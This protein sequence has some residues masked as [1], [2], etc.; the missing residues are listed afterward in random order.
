MRP[1]TATN[2]LSGSGAIAVRTIVSRSRGTS[3]LS[4]RSGAGSRV[5]TSTQVS[6]AVAAWNG[7][8]P[9]SRR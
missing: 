8:R 3:G 7:G 9:A 2:R 5:V 1:S 4:R 6:N